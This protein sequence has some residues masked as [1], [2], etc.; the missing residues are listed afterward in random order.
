MKNIYKI[1]GVLIGILGLNSCDPLKD[2]NKEL[3]NS[4]AVSPT[5]IAY[6]LTSDD[7]GL[8]CSEDVQ[9]FESFSA[10]VPPDNDTCGVAQI[11][12]QKFVGVDGDILNATYNLYD[13]L[14]KGT[15]LQYQATQADYDRFGTFSSLSL[16]QS[17]IIVD[18]VWTATYG[19]TAT[20]TDVV[21]LTANYYDGST[22]H[23]DTLIQYIATGSPAWEQ[24]YVLT[25]DDYTAMDQ[26]HSNFGSK[27]DGLGRMTTWMNLFFNPYANEG[28]VQV[29]QYEVYNRDGNE[30]YVVYFSFTN[31]A[32]SYTADTYPA[33]DAF[34]WKVDLQAWEIAPVY[35]FTNIGGDTHDKEYTLTEAD[36]KTQGESY[37]NFD[38]RYNSQEDIDRKI[39]NILNAQSEIVIEDGDI[40]KVN[41]AVYPTGTAP[42]TGNYQ[43]SL[44]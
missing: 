42:T 28:D 34:K 8:S 43:A 1:A 7:Y 16:S 15:S 36:Y 27:D 21:A 32:W 26:S 31:S 3:E 18:S 35:T 40:I 37:P 33:T 2:I 38:T 44:P 19:E 4:S 29:L 41:Y 17:I 10:N 30:E 24:V 14:F 12:D 11:L 23:S 5:E 6:T 22:T 25:A 39:G 20:R 13:P 9:N